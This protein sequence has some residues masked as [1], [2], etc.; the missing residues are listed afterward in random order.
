MSFILLTDIESECFGIV[1]E[2]VGTHI[3]KDLRAGSRNSDEDD[4]AHL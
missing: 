2:D 3:R 1:E 4:I